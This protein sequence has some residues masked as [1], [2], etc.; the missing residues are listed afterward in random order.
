MD[1]KE[2]FEEWSYFVGKINFGKSAMDARAISFMNEFRAN[3]K[4][5]KFDIWFVWDLDITDGKTYLRAVT[6]TE[7]R[8]EKYKKS[9][10]KHHKE[11]SNNKFLVDIEPRNTN[12]LF[13]EQPLENM[14]K[15]N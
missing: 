3:L 10:E 4:K 12:H 8:A 15:I 5:T 11:F 9:I 13:G 14:S 2:F 7:E 6:L 1:E